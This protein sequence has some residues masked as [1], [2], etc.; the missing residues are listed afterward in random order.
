MSVGKVAS[1]KCNHWCSREVLCF[2]ESLLLYLLRQ[3]EVC[4]G[5]VLPTSPNC[6]TA[7]ACFFSKLCHHVTV[8]VLTKACVTLLAVLPVTALTSSPHCTEPGG[9]LA[10][11]PSQRLPGWAFSCSELNRGLHWGLISIIFNRVFSL[12]F[13]P[14]LISCTGTDCSL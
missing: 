2:C 6:S 9:S 11:L 3:F 7:C 5:T 12:K 13:E 1:K 8:G 14:S 10:Y 4:A